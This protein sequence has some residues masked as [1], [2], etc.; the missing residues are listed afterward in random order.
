MSAAGQYVLAAT[1]LVGRLGPLALVLAL[2]ARERAP[3]Y[4]LAEE[5][6]RIG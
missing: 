6:V 5:Q 2:A 3:R 4:R 1:I